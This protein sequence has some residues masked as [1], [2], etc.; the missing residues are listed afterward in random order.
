MAITTAH[1]AEIAYQVA[2]AGYT[3]AEYPD[4]YASDWCDLVYE[5]C[6]VAD[7]EVLDRTHG[8][9]WHRLCARIHRELADVYA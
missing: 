4:P 1:I 6:S 3:T 5:Y 8:D 7:P 9:D 2:A